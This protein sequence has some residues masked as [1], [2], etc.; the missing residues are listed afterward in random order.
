MDKKPLIGVSI[1]TIVLLVLGSLSNVVGNQSVT[2][3]VNDSPLFQIRTQR[4]TNQRENI[5]T[6]K[7]LGIGK[8]NLLKFSSRDNKTEKLKMAIDIINRL[9]DKTF[10][11]FTEFFIQRIKQDDS[12]K[13][14]NPNDIIKG[15]K[16]I[17]SNPISII[18]PFTNQNNG[19]ETHS[20]YSSCPWIPGCYIGRCIEAIIGIIIIILLLTFSDWP[21][22]LTCVSY[23][24]MCLLGKKS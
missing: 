17:K 3:T 23:N 15:L 8:G 2:S 11:R 19:Y 13:E 21:N 5:L 1:C 7:Y 24:Y 22:T 20:G 12:L 9:D 4:A 16:L 6:S 18:I 10:E 14:T